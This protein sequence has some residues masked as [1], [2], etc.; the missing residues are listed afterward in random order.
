MSP[1]QA[2]VA[3]AQ[4]ASDDPL[5]QSGFSG[6]RLRWERLRRPIADAVSRSGPFLDV[7]C[8]NAVLLEDLVA[9][10]GDR[11]IGLDPWG[12]D[13]SPDLVDLARRRCPEWADHF[14]VGDVATWSPPRR[15]DVVRAELVYVDPV[16]RPALVRR[17]LD[18][19]LTPGGSLLVCR[20]LD[21]KAGT[22]RPLDG[23]LREELAGWGFRAAALFTGMD[24]D[25]QVGTAVAVLNAQSP[26]PA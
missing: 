11:G 5:E 25:G 12:L 14:L 10:C 7:G 4:L 8:A 22:A 16:A 2:Q 9:W 23:E 15:W 26:E 21:R 1:E 24:V 6:G 19:F 20:Y 17:L 13:V 18:N 3:A